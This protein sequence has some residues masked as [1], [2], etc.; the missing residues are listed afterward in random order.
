VGELRTDSESSIVNRQSSLDLTLLVNPSAGGGHAL[1]R[2]PDLSSVLGACGSVTVVEP[3]STGDLERA[4]REAAGEGRVVVIAGGDG[5]VHRVINALGGLPATIAVLPVG[6]GNDFSSSLGLPADPL[7]AAHRI[8]AGR[9]RAVDLVAVDGRLFCTVG[10]LGLVAQAAALV[11]R[12]AQPGSRLRP[13]VRALGPKAYLL[14]AAA[15]IAAGPVTM[16]IRIDAESMTGGWTW[17]GD[18][19]ALFVA[20][21]QLLG[22]GLRLPVP[23]SNTDG[24][25]EIAIVPRTG[26]LRL[27]RSLRCLETGSPVPPDVL[28]VRRATRATIAAATVAPFVAD[29]ELLPPASR[30]AVEVRPA[31][32]QV[33]A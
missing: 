19:H 23:S 26:R 11:A 25:C 17:S 32:L 29:G 16:G 2:W 13:A 14:A 18:A 21:Q 33:L 5:T 8:V 28:T 12:L 24:E 27:A 10:G 9:V 7:A 3:R 20:N 1:R 15:Y 6:S 22:A 4:A 31:A 30:F